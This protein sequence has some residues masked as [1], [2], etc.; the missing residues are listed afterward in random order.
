MN[1]RLPIPA[2]D[3]MSYEAAEWNMLRQG[4]RISMEDKLDWLEW[5][6]GLARRASEGFEFKQNEDRQTAQG[7]GTPIASK[8][9]EGK[10]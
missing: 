7:P 8:F 6:W 3:D 1:D 4:M 9:D 2:P 10:R 5:A